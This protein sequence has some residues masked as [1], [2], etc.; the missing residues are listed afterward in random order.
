MCTTISETW[1]WGVMFMISLLVRWRERRG[2]GEGGRCAGARSAYSSSTT[3]SNPSTDRIVT[4]S[5]P[6]STS[7]A[8]SQA[9]SRRLTV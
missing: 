9:E 6:A 1:V 4:R 2:A 3:A 5:R 8:S 7:P